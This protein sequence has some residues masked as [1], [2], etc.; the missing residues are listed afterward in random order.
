MEMVSIVGATLLGAGLGSSLMVP[1]VSITTRSR[2]HPGSVRQPMRS[3]KL[4]GF[5]NILHDYIAYVKYARL[6]CG[7]QLA[8]RD[9]DEVYPLKGLIHLILEKSPAADPAKL[10]HILVLRN[11]NTNQLMLED[12]DPEN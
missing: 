12:F 10:D 9:G 6:K 11:L 2:T 8:D 1:R 3:I 7:R 5:S 4:A